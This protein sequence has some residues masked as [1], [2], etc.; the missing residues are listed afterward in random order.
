MECTIDQLISELTLEEKLSMLAGVDMWHSQAIER[1]GI[2]A[3]R[4]TDGPN[5]ARGLGGRNVKSSASFPVGV[6]MGATWNIELIG[7]VGKALAEETRSK[8]AHILLGPTV[9]LHR[10]PLGGRNFESFSEDPYLSQC[11]AV[12]Y[13]SKMQEEGVGACVK[14][15]L[16]NDQEYDRYNLSS[17]VDERTL[18]EIYLLPFEGAVK[19]A[20]SWVVMSSYNKV[21]GT[22]LSEHDGLLLDV[23]KGEWQF[24]GLVISDWYG[25]YTSQVPTS[26]LDLEFPGPARWMG[27]EHV[28]NAIKD[29]VIDEAH[30]NKKVRRL[31]LTL[32]RT[33][34]FDNLVSEEQ[35]IDNPEHRA[36]IREVGQ[37]AIVLLKNKDNLLP[38]DV[39][40][41][42]TLAVI[43]AN[44]QDITFQGGGSSQVTPHYVVSPLEAIK[45]RAKGQ[46]SVE[47]AAG[48]D[49]K[50]NP[51]PLTAENLRT[52]DGKEGALLAE[53]YDNL[54]L[55]GEPQFVDYLNS[56]S[57]F[58]FGQ[59]HDDFDPTHFSLRL[60]GEF[61]VENS[62]RYSLVFGMM[63][64]AATLILDGE[65]AAD[66]ILPVSDGKV[67][68]DPEPVLIRIDLELEAERYYSI[69]IEY[70]TLAE[71]THRSVG[72]GLDWLD[73]PDL[74]GQSV[75]LAKRSDQVVIVAGL[76][77]EWESEGSDR[78]D[79]RLPNRQNE[80]IEKIAEVN[81]NVVVVLNLGSPVEMPWLDKVSGILQLW[82]L[83][84]ETGNA[85]AD[86]LFGDV[87]PSGKLPT[88]FPR[89]LK[90]NPTYINFPGENGRVNYGEGLFV[91]YRYYDKKEIAPL[92]PFGFGLS[93]TRFE[94]LS[95]SVPESAKCGDTVSVQC[96]VRN[97]G[98]FGGK[99]IVQLY[100]RDVD[101]S[102][103][104]PIKELKGFE[105]I[106]LLPGEEKTVE[107]TL[108]RRSFAFY[109]D[110][111]SDW[112]VE[113]GEFEIL[114][115]ASS[116]DIR[117]VGKLFLEE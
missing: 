23:L 113:P 70:V 52:L 63:G 24:D 117:L 29:G 67:N 72:M 18:R 79:M 115:G 84:Q 50:R 32:D 64:K 36:L 92:F 99:E 74:L 59:I 100:V 57:F 42:S 90:D 16:C 38:L 71:I 51:P 95:L 3:L 83:G 61:K 86:V 27:K 21:N 105:K 93:Y 5:G 48:V 107:F 53:F 110:Q 69:L 116:Q 80:L 58:L 54:D 75:D 96:V 34:A 108:G 46:F 88:T 15:Y 106:Q 13:I 35:A 4:V 37:E 31:L 1:L 112:V 45:H 82:Y 98:E 55:S 103:V 30:I 8:G 28:L 6:A 2:P 62:G 33:G 104:R 91:G 40:V 60:S 41:G 20:K 43:G 12:S 89:A 111:I 87:S 17:E 68:P 97:T 56:T 65:V 19:E 114:V 11:L 85:M 66:L 78:V 10:S 77:N 39:P 94:Y 76:T 25:T 9:N 47:Y 22:W 7:R 81:D 44:A 101:S 14:H 73:K 26:G 109:D 49:M 102:L